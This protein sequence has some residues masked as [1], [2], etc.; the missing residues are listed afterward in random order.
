MKI[1]KKRSLRGIAV[2]DHN[3]IE[4]GQITHKINKDPEF[5]VIIGAEIKT[6]YGDVIGLFLNEEIE[7]R[8]FFEVIDDIKSQDGL[9]ALAHPYRQY[10]RP[11]ELMEKVELVEVINARSKQ[12]TNR[13]SYEL[14][15]RYGKSETAGS[16]AHSGFEIGNV[17]INLA[18]DPR[19]AL[20]RGRNIVGGKETNYYLSHGLSIINENIK[21]IR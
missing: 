5:T 14:Q 3:T 7:N 1:A 13:R 15:K 16:D 17:W 6:E 12:E 8:N 21:K 19:K 9:V 10:S 20:L 2:I 4:G 11:E 18:G